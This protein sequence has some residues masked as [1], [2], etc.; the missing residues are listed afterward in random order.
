MDKPN[1]PEAPRQGEK[2]AVLLMHC[3]DRP[4]II[5]ILT[6]FINANGGN[7]IYLDQYVDRVNSIFYMRVQWDLEG[8]AIPADKIRDYFDTL[9]AQRFDVTYKLFFTG[10]PQRMAIFVS[11]MSHCIYDLLARYTAGEWKE[12]NVEIPVIV[13][14]HPDLSYIADQFGIPFEVIPV[15]RDNKPEAEA[16]QFALLEHYN[17]DFVVLARYMQVLSDDFIRR[18]PDRVINI[19]H[20]FLPAFIGSKPYHAA[21]QRGVKL[22]GATSHYVTAD[23]DAGPIIEQDIVRITHKD[24]VDDLIKKGRDLEKI[25][26]AR[27]VEKHLQHKILTYRNKTVVFN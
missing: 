10:T 9:Y 24:T 19:H 25:V 5:A 6:E 18:Y 4:G 15:T 3:P 8:F 26:L 23:L 22:I 7:I 2:S 17:I 21:Y 14:N 20:S 27:A 1:T 13:S 16:R 12:W 11:K